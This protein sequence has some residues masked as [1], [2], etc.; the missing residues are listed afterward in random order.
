MSLAADKKLP[1]SGKETVVPRGI[2]VKEREVRGGRVSREDE[3]DVKEDKE[4]VAYGS[5]Q[6]HPETCNRFRDAVS[7]SCKILVAR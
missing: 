6:Q 2:D 3:E 5:L 7:L 1:S 4:N